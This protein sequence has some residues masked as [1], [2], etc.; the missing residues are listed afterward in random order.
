[1]RFYIAASPVV[2]LAS[3][4]FL[5]GFATLTPLAEKLLG[6]GPLAKA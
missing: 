6:C 2:A 1:M 5:S 3:R 4:M